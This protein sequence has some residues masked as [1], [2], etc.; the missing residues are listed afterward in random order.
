MITKTVKTYWVKIYV[1]GP[2]EVVKQ[3]CRQECLERG[4]CVTVEPTTFIYTGGEEQG[5]VIGLVNYPRF[6]TSA[7]S[8]RARA[9][10]LAL[11]VLETT[12]QHSVMVMTP[13]DTT[14]FSKRE[15]ETCQVRFVDAGKDRPR[16]NLDEDVK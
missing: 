16:E 11:A 5:A 7:G 4:L 2:I 9:Q 12:C 6:P 10:R 1:S 15:E 14:W 13:E 8:I 3:A